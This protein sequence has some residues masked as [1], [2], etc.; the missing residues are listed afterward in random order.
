[1][2]RHALGARLRRPLDHL[3]G[4]GRHCRRGHY[5]WRWCRA[6]SLLQLLDAFEGSAREAIVRIQR[7]CLAIIRDG[8]VGVLFVFI[9]V[10]AINVREDVFR[11]EINRLVVVGDSAVK[12]ALVEGVGA[13]AIVVGIGVFRIEFDRFVEVG[14][15]A[16]VI[17]LEFSVGLA[18]IVVR[19]DVFR[20]EFERLVVVGE[21]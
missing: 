17:L 1:L 8:A 20:I 6:L 19:E 11:I 13:A 7:K 2:L 9:G 10:A 3:G 18:A 16:V 21:G 12:I 15:S 5:F 4:R 14:D